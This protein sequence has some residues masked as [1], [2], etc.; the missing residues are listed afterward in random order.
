[1]GE[2]PPE[3]VVKQVT[4]AINQGEVA[5]LPDPVMLQLAERR[6]ERIQQ[7]RPFSEVHYSPTVSPRKDRNREKM[8]RKIQKN[9]RRQNRGK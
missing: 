2:T 8:K 3:P 6:L 5:P 4:E 1:M 9:S 7:G